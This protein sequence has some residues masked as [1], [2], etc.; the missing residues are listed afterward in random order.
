M[1]EAHGAERVAHG[2]VGIVIAV[3]LGHILP[4]RYSTT[5]IWHLHHE[6][7]T[8]VLPTL[9]PYYSVSAPSPAEN[10]AS[11]WIVNRTKAGPAL[12]VV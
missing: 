10:G 12:G 8:L 5:R 2:V 4:H 6:K 1:A 9:G 7:G 11:A 3:S